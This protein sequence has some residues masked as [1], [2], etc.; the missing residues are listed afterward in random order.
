VRSNY[1]LSSDQKK[2]KK[3]LFVDNEPDMTALLKM[4]LEYAGFS[5]DVFN[6]PLLAL[7][8]FK[9]K[10]YDLV[11]LDVMMPKMDGLELYNQLK[12]VD[13]SVNGCFLT[14]SSETY[15]EELREKKGRHC[16][17]NKDPFLYMPLPISKIVEEIN[18]RIK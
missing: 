14:A 7:K 18:R 2:K 11:V 6:D 10:L 4:A 9:P 16:E 13:P 1:S 8:N 17:L 12:T 5:V 3:I 15:S